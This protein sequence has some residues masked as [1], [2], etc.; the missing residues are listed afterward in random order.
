M[1]DFVGAVPRGCPSLFRPSPILAAF[2]VLLCL[3]AESRAIGEDRSVFD[4]QLLLN[5]GAEEP[6]IA[7]L[8][9]TPAPGWI[10]GRSNFAE[11]AYADGG[12]MSPDQATR[13]GGGN[14][15]FTGGPNNASSSAYQEVDVR[16]A[17]TEVDAGQAS[18]LLSAQ[19]AGYG[20]EDDNGRVKLEFLNDA[21]TAIGSGLLLGP[22]H[23]NQNIWKY[24]R[25]ISV[26]P[27]KT[28]TIRVW[29]MAQRTSFNF[30]DAY[31]DNVR[32]HLTKTPPKAPQAVP[33]PVRA[34]AG[35][36]LIR[37]GGAEE[38]APT[39]P[40]AADI[41][42]WSAT[43]G[44][45][46]ASFLIR[47]AV[48]SGTNLGNN[49]FS[50][51]TPLSSASQEIDLLA[52]AVDPA[53]VA[54][55]AD[56]GRLRVRLGFWMWTE[57]GANNSA[58]VVLDEQDAGGA[59]VASL[60]AARVTGAAPVVL[61]N[62]EFPIF[63]SVRKLTV[64][65]LSESL[66][67]EASLARFDLVHAELIGGLPL[68]APSLPLSPPADPSFGA[69]LLRNPG[70]ED[71]FPDFLDLNAV[72]PIPGWTLTGN[73]TAADYRAADFLMG[74]EGDRISGGASFFSG[75]PASPLSTATQVVD[76][77]AF[78]TEVDAGRAIAHFEAWMG[79]YDV[80]GDNASAVATFL[81][82]GLNPLGA[83]NL[84]PVSGTSRGIS[85]MVFRDAS[86][87][88]PPGARFIQAMLISQRLE[89]NYN[90]GYFDKI[91]LSLERRT[92]PSDRILGDLDGDGVATVADVVLLLRATL[93]LV[94]L[95]PEQSLLADLNQDGRVSIVDA[96]VLLRR[97]L[98]VGQ[99]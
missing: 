82:A 40:A 71:S 16:A 59:V 72:V 32:L 95:T 77:T 78:S 54:A 2:L 81:D 38:G 46:V 15:Y 39:T 47:P 93:G 12:N 8:K 90:D 51:S 45:G 89:G 91:G 19:L 49:Y 58:R 26:A 94:T 44:F 24:Y 64:R 10:T 1:N 61:Y 75:G 11:A 14:A 33:P 99:P 50:G 67:E 60:E 73:F 97:I 98:T 3:S 85:K 21:G 96:P 57:N 56:A 42:G 29:L 87:P 88:V 79:G 48:I 53:T 74:P 43:A 92:I 70:A 84:L 9:P 28:R 52:N 23:G 22:Q 37:N 76:A 69:N 80:G 4:R 13:I 6:A 62:R 30:N 35:P 86:G 55:D 27:A 34:A 36:D 66:T 17:A 65:L 7:A 5:P 83:L 18:V 41:P 25:K 68:P 20:N 63:P 31:F